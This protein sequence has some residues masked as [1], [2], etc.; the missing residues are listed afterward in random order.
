MADQHLTFDRALFYFGLNYKP[1]LTA[2]MQFPLSFNQRLKVTMILLLLITL[3]IDSL[4]HY[5]HSAKGTS[6]CILYSPLVSNQKTNRFTI[7]PDLV[8]IIVIVFGIFCI[9]GTQKKY[10]IR[11]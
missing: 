9:Q 3:L 6:T 11:T 4:I 5:Q 7:S 2:L 8:L 10:I 1:K